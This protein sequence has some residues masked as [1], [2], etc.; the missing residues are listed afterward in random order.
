M[1]LVAVCSHRFTGISHP[2]HNDGFQL[3][4]SKERGRVPVVERHL[5]KVLKR[6]RVDDH[7]SDVTEVLC[8]CCRAHERISKGAVGL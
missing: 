5:L 3:Q 8:H 6:P 7:A 1:N 2:I 4:G